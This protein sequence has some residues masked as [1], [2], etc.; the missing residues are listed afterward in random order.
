MAVEDGSP[1]DEGDDDAGTALGFRTVER[2][3]DTRLPVAGSLPAWLSGRFVRNGPGLFEAGGREIEHWFD[4]PAL[5]RGFGFEP[6]DDP[7]DERVHYVDRFLRTEAYAAARE[8]RVGAAGFAES[9]SR[10][11]LDRLRNLVPE[12]TDNANADVLRLGGTH[13]AVTES[14]RAVR[15]DPETLTTE[16]ELRWRDDLPVGHTTPHYRPLPEG[17]H[18]G[19]LTTFLPRPSYRVFRVPPG[20]PRREQLARV[21]VDRPSYMHSPAVA[22][23]FA[24]LVEPPFDIAPHRV[25]TGQGSLLDRY[26]WRPQ[27]GTRFVVVD[28][29]TGAVVC[30]PRTAPFLCFHHAN[31]WREGDELVLDLVAFD[32]PSVLTGMYLDRMR[33]RDGG[34]GGTLRR[35]R[36]PLSGATPTSRTLAE[37]V[38]MPTVDDRRTGR[39][40]RHV[41]AQRAV[42]GPAETVV[43]IDVERETVTAWEAEAYVSEPVFVPGPD[44]DASASPPARPEGVVL[45][46]VLDPETARSA[47]VVLDAADM[48]ELARARTPHALPFGFHGSYFE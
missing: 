3:Y 35:Y 45:V 25:L 44:G 11:L 42:D 7:D 20:E 33:A 13:V 19:Y 5:L 36:V 15:F 27:R 39:R 8:G 23:R 37:G 6:A 34:T 40:S 30:E 41:F 32:S 18:L 17:G 2:E 9:A 12:P 4:G 10:G 47:V 26:E 1:E 28:R 29:E 21:P 31:A 46:E 16:G 38:A 43:R 48:T 24:V 22:G 14:P